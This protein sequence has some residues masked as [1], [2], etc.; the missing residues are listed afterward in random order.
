M[1]CDR[2]HRLIE[3]PLDRYL[4]DSLDRS[5]FYR[6]KSELI[7]IVEATRKFYTGLVDHLLQDD[8]D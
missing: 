3:E 2:V 1:Y 5:P 7:S 4:T 8:S 6:F